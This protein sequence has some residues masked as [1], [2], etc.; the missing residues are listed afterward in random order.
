MR[1]LFGDD[2]NVASWVASRIEHMNGTGFGE[3]RAVGIMRDEKPIAGMVYHDYSGAHET[4]AISLA[5]ESPHWATRT[6]LK[7]IL[8]IPFEQYGCRKVWAISAHT[9]PKVIKLMKGIGFT[10]EAVLRHQLAHGVHGVVCGLLKKEYE[11]MFT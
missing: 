7:A 11:R 1:L 10:Q 6:I 4:C 2:A 5:A 8:G 9:N 3:C